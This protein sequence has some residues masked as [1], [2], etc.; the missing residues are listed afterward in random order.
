MHTL[1][2][3]RFHAPAHY[4]FCDGAVEG[5]GSL[6]PVPNG[7]SLDGSG[8]LWSAGRGYGRPL[9]F[10]LTEDGELVEDAVLAEKTG[11][12]R[13]AAPIHPRRRL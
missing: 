3:S 10:R 12:M 4:A 2:G 11:S 1:R 6:T 9:D 8:R 7:Y 5:F 13:P